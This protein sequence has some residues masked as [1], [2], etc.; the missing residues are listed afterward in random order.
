MQKCLLISLTE[1]RQLNH[2]QIGNGKLQIPSTNDTKI[3]NHFFQSYQFRTPKKPMRRW[4]KF[5]ESNSEKHSRGIRFVATPPYINDE[6][7]DY[8]NCAG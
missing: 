6:M 2:R 4:N 3:T 5:D 8:T 7:R 1:H